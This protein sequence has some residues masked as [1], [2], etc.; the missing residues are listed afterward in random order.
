MSKHF[1]SPFFIFTLFFISL[2]AFVFA[3]QVMIPG[4]VDVQKT[5]V[6]E[7]I[8]NLYNFALYFGGAL[9]VL[10]IVAGAIYYTFSAAT[11]S[12]KGR[13]MDMIWGALWGLGLLLGAYLI[14]KTTNSEL[15]LL[16]GP[17]GE[18][19][20]NVNFNASST[21]STQGNTTPETP[22]GGIPIV[23]TG[24]DGQLTFN[25]A[26]E[27]TKKE[28]QIPFFIKN[29]YSFSLYLAGG[30]AIIMLVVGGIYYLVS[31]ASPSG[32]G[33]GKEI[34]IGAALGLL[35]IVGSYLIL[36]TVNPELVNL[37]NPGGDLAKNVDYQNCV[38]PENIEKNGGNGGINVSSNLDF[39]K[40]DE[41][42]IDL[43]T[44]E[45]KCYITKQWEENLSFIEDS[46]EGDS[47]TSF[48]C[49]NEKKLIGKEA[50]QS[51][52]GTGKLYVDKVTYSNNDTKCAKPR[53]RPDLGSADCSGYTYYLYK[54]VMGVSLGNSGFLDSNP[55]PDTL[56]RFKGSDKQQKAQVG[57]IIGMDAACKNG[58]YG[59]VMLVAE[60]QGNDVTKILDVGGKPC[61]AGGAHLR[62]ISTR[63]RTA[64]LN[65][66]YTIHIKGND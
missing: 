44:G 51:I 46:S 2:P 16:R 43:K 58:K 4:S 40:L 30:A 15:V 61:G 8:A 25:F 35:L 12:Q 52:V 28:D 41:Y 26:E 38:A 22:L 20:K 56:E 47:F 39:C 42:P 29:F 53:D 21:S 6:P 50:A 9:A 1:Y 45:C 62:E 57:D 11:P 13:G 10:M 60:K 64:W 33:K 65:C 37:Q 36:K 24:Q 3:V 14:L 55:L 23:T 19:A 32:Q 66:G 18:I 54:C 48:T 49:T 5:T 31:A 59:H 34:V 27:Q 17:G 63:M 7:F